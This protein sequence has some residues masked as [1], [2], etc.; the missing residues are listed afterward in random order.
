MDI[1]KQLN[2]LA[3][4]SGINYDLTHFNVALELLGNPQKDIKYIHIAGTNGKGTTA[5]F[6]AQ[7]LEFYKKKVGL[8]SSPHLFSYTE[9]FKIN[10]IPINIKEMNAY[11]KE[12]K[13][14]VQNIPLTEFEILTLIAFLFFKNNAPDFVILETGLGGRL[15]ATNVIMPILTVITTISYDH[16][17]LLG[18]TLTKIATEKAGIIKQN[19]PLITFQHSENILNIFKQKAQKLN[20]PLFYVNPN[21]NDYLSNNKLLAN[22]AI[23]VLGFAPVQINTP[24]ILG[25][26]QTI[27]QEPLIIADVAHNL[28]GI[29]TLVNYINLHNLKTNILFSVSQKQDA[30]IQAMA[31]TISQAATTL[32]ITEFDYYKAVSLKKIKELTKH[33]QNVHFLPKEEAKRLTVY[34]KENLVITGSIYFLGYLLK[35]QKQ[36][37]V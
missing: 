36:K 26:M 9:R 4:T 34:T 35:S 37:Q 11:L 29:Q 22:K 33:I 1:E 12:I 10:N 3:K 5:D 21:Q 32:F 31:E 6:I 7:S 16:Q 23:E 18:N 30:D 15:D 27:S 25:R 8:Y 13:Q 28:E 2:Q 24:R 20:C 14:K 17:A 19:T